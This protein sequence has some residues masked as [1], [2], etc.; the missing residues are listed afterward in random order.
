MTHQNALPMST[1]DQL[2]HQ[3]QTKVLVN[4]KNNAVAP[5]GD[6]TMQQHSQA[7]DV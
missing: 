4:M 1:E 3:Q 6:K 5:G 2:Q 7:S